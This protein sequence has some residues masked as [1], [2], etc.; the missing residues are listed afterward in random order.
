MS[1]ERYQYDVDNPLVY[2]NA[3]GYYKTER[4]LTFIKRFLNRPGRQLLDI[5]GGGGRLAV[6]IA[7]LGHSITV[8]DVSA[9]ALALLRTRTN[10]TVDVIHSDIM[11]FQSQKQF[12]V[13]LAIDTL[14]YVVSA[15]LVDV[16]KTINGLMTM[17]GVFL[18]ADI[19]KG[20]WRNRLSCLLGRRNGQH[21]NID[22]TDGYIETFKTAGFEVVAV[23]G[24]LWMPFAFNSNSSLVPLFKVV[25]DVF[26]L[27]RWTKQSPWLLFAAKRCR[28]R[29]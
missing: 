9:E 28:E 17:D 4:Q 25:E 15:P 10:N 5:G 13:V 8:L 14:K 6:P 26:H 20:S 24:F 19:N 16:F 22:S 27:R 29:S 7:S 23:T 2:K 11:S 21:Y 1:S 3:M 12:D 18:F